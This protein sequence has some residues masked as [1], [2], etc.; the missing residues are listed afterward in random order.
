MK[1][2]AFT[3]QLGWAKTSLGGK[4]FSLLTALED[5]TVCSSSYGLCE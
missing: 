4:Q 3:M 2:D 5:S 1:R